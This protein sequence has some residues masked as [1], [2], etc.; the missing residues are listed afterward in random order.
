MISKLCAMATKHLVCDT[1]TELGVNVKVINSPVGGSDNIFP[2]NS[3]DKAEEFAR[4]AL[5]GFY[6][7]MF[8]ALWFYAHYV[9][10]LA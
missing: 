5:V 3:L 2:G 9:M 1:R 7:K 8:V 4:S 6:L 10:H